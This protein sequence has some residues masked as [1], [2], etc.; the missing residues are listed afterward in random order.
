MST[1]NN[2]KEKVAVVDAVN[3]LDKAMKIREQV[4]DSFANFASRVGVGPGMD[5]QLSAGFYQFNLLT[6]NRVQLEAAYRGSWV[7]GKIVDSVAEDMTKAGITVTSS[8]AAEDIQDLQAYLQQIGLWGSLCDT[9]KWSRLYG[10][11]IGVMQIEG[12]KLDTPLRVDTVSKGQFT[13]LTVYDRWQLYPD[14]NNVIRSGP[15]LGLPAYYTII[16]SPM[17]LAPQADGQG[18]TDTAG[19]INSGIR[20]HHSRIVRMAGIKLPFFQAIT[21]QMWGM[22]LIERVH[23][24]LVSFDQS[25]MSAANLINHAHLRTVRVDKLRDV[26]ATGGKAMEGMI[27]M[28]EYMRLFQS[29]EGLTLLD[30]EDESSTTSYSFAGLADMMVQFGQQL[31]GASEIPLVRMF[32]QSPAG[33]NSTGESDLKNYYG[34]INAKQEATLRNPLTKILKVA[35]RSRFGKPAPKDLQYTFTSL[36]QET[37]ETKATVARTK[38][39]TVAGQYESG[40]VPRVVALKELRQQSAE[41]G[42]WTNITDEMIDEAEKENDLDDV[43]MP[44]DLGLEEEKKPTTDSLFKRII[45][46]LGGKK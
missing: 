28:F 7:V 41:T 18:M 8:E 31:S 20:V 34:D 37:G 14:V 46:K 15:D 6:R 3:T 12:Q 2:T 23:D 39:E 35:Y 40:L 11:A 26:I 4:G 25:T 38:T 36:W 33:L 27:A 30:K 44:N 32:G 17:V 24:R 43:P 1:E 5:N 19:F 42:L 16:T 29:N 13:G 45:K 10:G 22:S 21:E 9:I